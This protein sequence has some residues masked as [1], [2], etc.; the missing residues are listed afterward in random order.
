M[1]S[2]L[3][4]DIKNYVRHLVNNQGCDQAA[5]LLDRSIRF[6][7]DLRAQVVTHEALIEQLRFER[8][9]YERSLLNRMTLR[10][11]DQMAR[12]AACSPSVEFVATLQADNK[13]LTEERD[14]AKEELDAAKEDI[15]D[16]K[17]A[18]ADDAQADLALRREINDLKEKLKNPDEVA[19]LRK[20]IKALN[21]ILDKGAKEIHDLRKRITELNNDLSDRVNKNLEL[22]KEIKELKETVDKDLLQ[23]HN[24]RQTITDLKAD[25][26]VRINDNAALHKKIKEFEDAQKNTIFAS[27]ELGDLRKEIKRLNEALAGRVDEVVGLRA[28]RHEWHVEKD[29]LIR[30]IKD[31][32]DALDNPVND[33]A[34]LRKTIEKLEIELAEHRRIW[35][36]VKRAAEEVEYAAKI[37]LPK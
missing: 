2:D 13:K 12:S 1:T 9:E 21:E 29:R 14:K 3:L 16:L 28:G 35:P 31:L 8:T 26:N 30:E 22:R 17:N 20:E 6:I 18:R 24:A 37:G 32:N 11:K 4:D 10:L 5:R 23:L 36:F 34:D 25:L 7:C 15:A 33:V 19:A 27:C